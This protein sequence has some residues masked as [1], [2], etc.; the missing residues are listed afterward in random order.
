MYYIKP[1][2]DR[3]LATTHYAPIIE[4]G[5]LYCMIS[6]WEVVVL[7]E[8]GRVKLDDGPRRE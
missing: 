5:S 1:P 2:G 4:I 7:A 8:R 3:V 6:V